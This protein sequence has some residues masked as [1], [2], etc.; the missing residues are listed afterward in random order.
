[1][2]KKFVY[3]G[4]IL[5]VIAVVMFI[6]FVITSPFSGV[7]SK[8][9]TMYNVSVSSGSFYDVPLSTTNALRG[10][11]FV[12]L[13][14]GSANVYLFN[15]STFQAWNSKVQ[16][17]ATASG[18]ASARTLGPGIG[19]L[20]ASNVNVSQITLTENLSATKANASV[21]GFS[22][23]N[24]TAY[25]V[26]DNTEGSASSN[27]I[28]KGAVLYLALTQSNLS[29]Y[30]GIGAEVL[31]IGIVEIALIIAGLVLVIYGAMKKDSDAVPGTIDAKGEASKE[32]IDSLYK[33]VDKKKKKSD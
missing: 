13:F 1:M 24:G 3:I 11:V 10:L 9:T 12:K 29:M 7:L 21:V 33:N 8:I 20:I 32:Y 28:V 22:G 5:L 4:L 19:A 31:I 23:F 16:G 27:T 17:N 14:N 15:A 26:I 2:R 18:I 25:L 30:E 6:I